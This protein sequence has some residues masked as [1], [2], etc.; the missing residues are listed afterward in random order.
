MSKNS[1]IDCDGKVGVS[2]RAMMKMGVGGFMGL[3]MMDLLR[4]S[5]LAGQTDASKCDSVVLFWLAGGPSH[6]DTWDP[7]PG[8]ETGGPYKALE[9]SA[10]G[11]QICEHMPTIAKVMKHSAIIRSM[12]SKE[13][14]HE[15]ATYEMHTGYKQLG[16]IAHPPM[17]SLITQQ[18]G[19]RNEGLPAYVH[20]GRSNIFGA[21]FL[22]SNYAP[23]VIDSI[24]EPAKNI[25]FPA[26]VEDTRFKR[27]IDILNAVDKEFSHKTRGN[28]VREYGSYYREAMKMIYSKSLET[29]DLKQEK[30]STL[31]AYGDNDLGRSALMARRFVEAGVR[32][33][34]ITM[35]GWDTHDD[36][37]PK[38][39][40]NLSRLDP[41]VGNL[42]DDLQ[43]RGLLKRT[44][45]IVTGE[46][47]RTPKINPRDGRDHYPACF[48]SFIAGGGI[49][50]GY[51]HGSSDA[52]GVSVKDNP[53]TIGDLH[54][55]MYDAMGID[56]TKEN[57]T[58]E[59]RP[60]RVVDK[61]K[62]VKELLA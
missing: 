30:P 59:G 16:S 48:S 27:R 29:F 62:P 41:A 24:N 54:A 7:K 4:A 44:M 28:E 2:R 13:G 25:L 39:Q 9:T 45:V 12:T 15:R 50:Q 31:Q 3:G 36:A 26:E 32:F 21:G 47:G 8:Q 1:M 46:F 57:I 23:Y 52:K 33:V 20:I 35:G 19:R 42:V 37:F 49:K 55:T 22:G 18:K 58:P 5:V 53:V 40:S 6:I 60:I 34:E 43:A 10:S 14:S 61:G 11:I 17:G 38:I 51:V 56:F